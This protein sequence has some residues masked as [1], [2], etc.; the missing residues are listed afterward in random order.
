MGWGCG[1]GRRGGGG[2]TFGELVLNGKM[3]RFE[4]IWRSNKMHEWKRRSWDKTMELTRQSEWLHSHYKLKLTD[5]ETFWTSQFWF[6][7]V[8]NSSPPQAPKNDSKKLLASF[9]NWDWLHLLKQ[10]LKVASTAQTKQGKI[11]MLYKYSAF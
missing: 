2:C 3:E 9:L 10:I 7:F 4:G 1:G 8:Q 5:R 11:N 6:E